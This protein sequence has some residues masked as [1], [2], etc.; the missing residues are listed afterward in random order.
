MEKSSSKSKSRTKEDDRGVSPKFGVLRKT[1]SSTE[2]N[3][4]NNNRT[5]KQ[6]KITVKN[7]ST[8]TNIKTQ[9]KKMKIRKRK[10]Q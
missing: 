7:R 5:K 8:L 10:Y 9:K 4:T 3:I 1:I 2:T 6:T